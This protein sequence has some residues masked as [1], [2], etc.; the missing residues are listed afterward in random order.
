MFKVGFLAPLKYNYWPNRSDGCAHSLGKCVMLAFLTHPL[1]SLRGVER[2]TFPCFP[3]S[4]SPAEILGPLVEVRPV[5]VITPFSFSLWFEVLLPW[6]KELGFPVVIITEVEISVRCVFYLAFLSCP[7][8]GNN[9]WL[10][11]PFVFHVTYSPTPFYWHLE[12]I[13]I[14]TLPACI[15][16]LWQVF[17]F[18]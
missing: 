10:C 4:L 3:T 1:V 5:L 6:K 18:W 12:F 16:Y 8:K 11:L 9:T 15:S 2:L 13:L 7:T 17:F 14:S